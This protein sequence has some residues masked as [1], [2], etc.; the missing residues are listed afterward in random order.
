MGLFPLND[1]ARAHLRDAAVQ[2]A[3]RLGVFSVVD[4]G[5]GLSTIDLAHRLHIAPRRLRALFDVLVLEGVLSRKDDAGE[6]RFGLMSVPPLS[7]PLPASGW[8]LLDE[9]IRRDHP[10]SEEATVGES[11]G[12]L[13]HFHQHLFET[14]A[15]AARELFGKLGAI[16]PPSLLD[17]GGGAGAFTRAFLDT[18]PGGSATLVDRAAVVLL[19]RENLTDGN[20]TF[21]SGE[22]EQTKFQTAFG[23]ALLANVLHLHGTAACERLVRHVADSVV[24]GGMVAIV[25]VDVGPDRIGPAPGLYFALNMAL[26]T[27]EGDAH[28]RNRIAG[29]LRAAGLGEIE[30]VRLASDPDQIAVT[31]RR[32]R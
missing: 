22:I 1:A 8:G 31:G 10:L 29:W 11:G 9:V 17:A 2:A 15:P 14:C 13:R 20:V 6:S 3:H 19:A 24:P 5:D 18:H 28:D 23:V 4:S 32:R 27:T 30:E 25:E 21:L 12:F 26:Y 7:A 16:A